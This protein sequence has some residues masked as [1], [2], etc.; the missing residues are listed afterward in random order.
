MSCR[1]LVVDDHDLLREMLADALTANNMTVVA[2]SSV[3]EAIARLGEA[4]FDLVITDVRFPQPPHGLELVDHVLS[5]AP[6]T[7]VIVAT[8][9]AIAPPTHQF[10]H[11]L[12]KPFGVDALLATVDAAL[13]DGD[14][15]T[16]A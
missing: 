3:P 7:R 12:R 1:V 15:L 8:G 13:G 2:T 6:A 9:S 14:E 10:V 5:T 4:T 11:L 16:P